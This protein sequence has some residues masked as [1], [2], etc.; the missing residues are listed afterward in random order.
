M[1]RY[2]LKK[3]YVELL[4]NLEEG[5]TK[6]KALS[7]RIG[8]QY[9]HLV[10]VIDQFVKEGIVFKDKKNERVLDLVL[11]DKGNR[12]VKALIELKKAIEEEPEAPKEEKQDDTTEPESDTKED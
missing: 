6:L 8:I 12:I 1:Y 11:T 3:N 2:V 4:L 9:S 5:E 7:K 10:N